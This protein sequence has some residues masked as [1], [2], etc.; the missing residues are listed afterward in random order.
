MSNQNIHELDDATRLNPKDATAPLNRG[1]AYM[2]KGDHDKAFTDY[3]EVIRLELDAAIQR[4]PQDAE[5]YYNRALFHDERG[6]YNLAISDYSEAIRL[7]PTYAE[8]YHGRG[9]AYYY[10]AH[11]EEDRAIADYNQ[12]IQIYGAYS[13]G[14][15]EVIRD[16]GLIYENRETIDGYSKAIADY[17][18]AARNGPQHY[19]ELALDVY[20]KRGNLYAENNDYDS[21]IADMSRII[22]LDDGISTDYDEVFRRGPEYD[23]DSYPSNYG[24]VPAGQAHNDRGFYYFKKGEYDRAIID[25]T[26][27]LRI[28]NERVELIPESNPDFVI[29]YL[30]L[31]SVYQA[32]MDYNMAIENCD[33]V[34]RLCPNYVEDCI[35][36]KFANGGQEQVDNAVKLLNKVIEDCDQA[37]NEAA[38]AYY[39]GVSILFSGNRHKARRRLERAREL[40]FEDDN[41]IAKHFENLKS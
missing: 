15:A 12:A 38:A 17:E 19:Y 5:T 23:P 6:D 40:G 2:E 22:E 39:A 41:K 31:N 36:S 13:S 4:N 30:N 32:K 34:V 33:N 20:F 14:R 1:D 28:Y 37:G 27:V 25:F 7:D 24:S 35:N 26:E 21:A 16:R 29:I 8:A 10:K 11:E 3:D 9:T 18:W